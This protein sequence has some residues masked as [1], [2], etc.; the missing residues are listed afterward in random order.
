MAGTGATALATSADVQ[1]ASAVIPTMDVILSAMDWATLTD[2]AT[3]SVNHAAGV[4]RAVTI[5]GNRTISNPTNTKPGWPLNIEITQDATGS[6]TI[7]WGTNFSFGS[8][9]APTLSTVAGTKDLLCFVCRSSTKYVF[10][11]IVK[12]I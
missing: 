3:I 8:D 12:G 7:S 10:T 6:R 4:N 11:G 1:A 2:G 9:G 5:A